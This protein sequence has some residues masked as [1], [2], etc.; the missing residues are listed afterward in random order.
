MARERLNM[1]KRTMVFGHQFFTH[2]WQSSEFNYDSIGSTVT[3]LL[4]LFKTPNCTHPEGDVLVEDAL[5]AIEEDL[6]PR[7]E[8]VKLRRAPVETTS[9]TTHNSLLVKK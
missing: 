5:E 9:K 8:G 4:I 2:I 7:V 3:R 6:A 1:G